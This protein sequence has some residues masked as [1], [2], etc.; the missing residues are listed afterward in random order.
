MLTLFLLFSS[1]IERIHPFLMLSKYI[2]A[3]L[4]Q[5]KAIIH[6]NSQVQDSFLHHLTKEN[7]ILLLNIF[8]VKAMC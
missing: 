4:P 3:F 7:K 1:F 8:W 2:L 5:K 6:P